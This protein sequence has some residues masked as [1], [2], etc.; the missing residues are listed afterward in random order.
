[1]K[2]ALITGVT[3]G[4]GHASTFELAKLGYDTLVLIARNSEKL[5]GVKN[6]LLEKYPKLT[7][8]LKVCDLADFD[9][10]KK[11]ALELKSELKDS[12]IDLL[13][14]NAGIGQ[15]E[16]TENKQGFEN[17]LATNYLSQVVLTEHL[18][19]NLNSKARV[20]F[21]SSMAYQGAN[22]DYDDINL[23]QGFSMFRAYGNSKAFQM[24]YNR[25]LQKRFENDLRNISFEAIHPGVVKTNWGRGDSNGF[26]KLLFKLGSV[27]MISPEYS[28]SH[29]VLAPIYEKNE[30]FLGKSDIWMDGKPKIVGKS[31]M[32]EEDKAKL[33]E[34]TQKSLGK[35]LN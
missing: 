13:L 30:A 15:F 19:E 9:Q 2:T 32:K 27:F 28:V 21:V 29:N 7:I 12:G 3:S 22:I 16:H 17:N 4:I 35:W 20:I 33:W 10:V 25:Q 24:V 18:L 26:L 11:T 6:E 5:L 23:K 1:M 31:F 8:V 34:F 14:N